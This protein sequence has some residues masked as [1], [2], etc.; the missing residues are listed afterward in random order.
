MSLITSDVARITGRIPNP[1]IPISS[2]YMLIT[3][4]DS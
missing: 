1:A 3:G 4:Y 2:F